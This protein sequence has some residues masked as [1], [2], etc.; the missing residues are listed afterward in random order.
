L[1]EPGTDTKPRHELRVFQPDNPYVALGLA[2]SH[3]MTKP[4]FAALRFGEWSRVLVGQ[5]NRK[6]YYFVVDARNPVQ[7]FLGW[8]VTSKDKAEAWV[9]GRGGLSYDDEDSF[10]GASIIFNAWVAS[11]GKV[12]HLLLQEAR[13]I[14]W[15]GR[16]RS[17]SNAT[18][19]TVPR[20]P[21]ACGLTISS[22]RTSNRRPQARTDC[23]RRSTADA[24]S[25][26]WRISSDLSH[27]RTLS[28]MSRASSNSSSRMRAVAP[29]CSQGLTPALDC[30][31]G[32]RQPEPA[33]ASV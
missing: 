15:S 26:A 4:A 16:T 14:I 28:A 23:N 13:K 20:G 5:I 11:N 1:L 7:G 21:C 8:A 30:P 27:V 29:T 19:R 18:T 10:D 3:L 31:I 33:T 32:S 6:H 9:E 22:R 2:V 25:Q 17:T 12:N 24:Q